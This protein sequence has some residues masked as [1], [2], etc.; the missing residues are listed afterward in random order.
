MT[1]TKLA[2]WWETP[3]PDLIARM[4]Q[5]HAGD[6]DALAAL[7]EHWQREADAM[8]YRVE[9]AKTLRDRATALLEQSLT[10]GEAVVAPSGRV[11]FL[12]RVADGKA[13]VRPEAYDEHAE[14]L[15]PHLRPVQVTRYRSV[16]DLRKAAK[17]GDITWETFRLLVDEPGKRDGLQWRT[18]TP[19]TEEAAA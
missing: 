1:T 11:A 16:T 19:D 8:A 9:A 7:V 6:G 15:P 14:T 5:A 4:E 18:L 10:A 17:A 13:S 2:E 12:G 3:L